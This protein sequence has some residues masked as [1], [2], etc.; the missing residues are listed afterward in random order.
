MLIDWFTVVAQALN[1][2]VLIWLM[3]R[4]LYKPVLDAI[5]ARENHI[6]AELADAAA[7]QAEARHE[8]DEFEARNAA[9]D[10]QRT[11]LLARATDAA[12]AEGQRL[13]DEAARAAEAT[14]T[15]RRSLLAGEAAALN[16]AIG[17]R[18]RQEVFAIVRE[19]LA[20]LATVE[21]EERVCEVFIGRLR[22]LDGP[23]R[24]RLGEAIGTSK[25]GA[26]VRSAFGLPPAQQ[27]AIGT[28]LN[29]MF[30]ARIA[31]RFEIAP[32][33]VAG[34]ELVVNGQKLDWN[35]ARYVEALGKSVDALVD[36]P[37]A[38]TA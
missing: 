4:F 24:D 17:L 27:A 12:R 19:T 5:D 28:A 25:D 11:D 7:K 13:I 36:A 2:G 29:T 6:A 35:I 16:V 18:T 33:L 32:D 31:L 8:R 14:A 22:A 9:F 10:Q 34:I 15:K 26:L 3:K 30:P 23:A 20:D 37:V 21:L 38:A 1:F